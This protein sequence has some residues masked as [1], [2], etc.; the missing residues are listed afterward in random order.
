MGFVAHVPGAEC[1]RLFENWTNLAPQRNMKTWRK[2]VYCGHGWEL[3][4]VLERLRLAKPSPRTKCTGVSHLL[5]ERQ[6]NSP[7]LATH[8]PEPA[9][10]LE[11]CTTNPF[12]LQMLAFVTFRLAFP[13]LFRLYIHSFI[14]PKPAEHL[15]CA[16]L[17]AG[18]GESKQIT[19][20]QSSTGEYVTLW[21]QSNQLQKCMQNDEITVGIRATKKR[22]VLRACERKDPLSWDPRAE[23]YQKKQRTSWGW[24][25]RKRQVLATSSQRS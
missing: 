22:W 7:G 4:G 8:Q 19:Q 2:N 6:W 15:P 25:L 14:P 16:R 11:A 10:T 12:S 5:S 17:G 23:L 3:L 20:R 21:G 18:G 13:L 9:S 1:P 24:G